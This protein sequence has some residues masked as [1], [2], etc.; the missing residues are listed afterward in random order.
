MDK[1][2]DVK[3]TKHG[4]YLYGVLDGVDFVQSGTLENGNKYGAS[5]KLRFITKVTVIKTV[6]GVDIPTLK[7]IA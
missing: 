7:A 5:V 2:K 6:D 1:S 3:V 4:N